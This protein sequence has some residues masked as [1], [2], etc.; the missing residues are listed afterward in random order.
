MLLE[1]FIPVA[2]MVAGVLLCLTL[3]YILRQHKNKGESPFFLMLIVSTLIW[4]LGYVFE[5]VFSDEKLMILSAKAEYLGIAFIPVAWF[6]FCSAY[7]GRFNRLVKTQLFYT[8]IIV[9]LITTFLAFTNQYHG[10]IWAK[11]EFSNIGMYRVLSPIHGLWFWAHVVYSHLLLITGS[12]LIIGNAIL[13]PSVYRKRSILIVS[14]ALLPWIANIGYLSKTTEFDPTPLAFVAS[15]FLLLWGVYRYRLVEIIPIARN[16]VVENLDDAVVVLDNNHVI[17]DMNPAAERFLALPK[18]KVIGSKAVEVFIECPEA[19]RLYNSETKVSRRVC[20]KR[21]KKG[22]KK[23]YDIKILPISDKSKNIL[24][25]LVVVHDVTDIKRAEEYARKQRKKLKL[26][27][28]R[29]EE[30][31]AE[32]TKEIEKLLKQKNEFINQL[33][34]DLKTPLTPLLSLLPV[35]EEKESD[36]DLKRLLDVVLRNARYMKNLVVDTL[37]LAK[38]NLPNLEFNL[39]GINLRDVIEDTLRDNEHIISKGNVNVENLV[40]DVYVKADRLR[41]KEVLTNLITNSVKFTPEG[42]RIVFY[43]ESAGDEVKVCIEDNGMGL[44]EEQREKIFDEFYKVD[45]SR[46]NVDSSGL[47]LT[48]CKRIIEKHGGR[49]W[50]ESEGV[51][52]GTRICFTLPVWDDEGEE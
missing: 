19:L 24:G 5:I 23:Y 18:D 20:I 1:S 12:V 11:I 34:H 29:L 39:E 43:T 22:V 44:E 40:D 21:G 52:K 51:G 38:L 7:T 15:A 32:R 6:S 37:N 3:I 17:V 31:V 42:G 41:V 8:L 28:E 30:K 49:I 4:S 26:L 35:I 45:E 9:P 16:V 13:L 25:R 48:I 27:N 50:A 14:A 33:G 2:L 36:P 47:G 10:L 46:H